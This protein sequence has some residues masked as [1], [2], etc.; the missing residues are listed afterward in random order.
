MIPFKLILSGKEPEA[1]ANLALSIV[2]PVPNSDGIYQITDSAGGTF[3]AYVD[4]TTD[5]GYWILAFRWT[6]PP[7]PVNSRTFN[8]LVVK[9]QPISGYSVLPATFPAIPAG[10]VTA[11]PATEYLLRSSNATWT[12]LFGTWQRMNTFNATTDAIVHNVGVPAVTSI[13]NRTMHGHRTGWGSPTTMNLVLGF[14]TVAGP[15]GHCGGAGIVGT[16]KCCPVG[17]QGDGGSHYDGTNSVKQV[18]LRA[19]NKP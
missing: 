10:R 17:S 3:P 15:N 12:S 11:N 7:A 6:L 1:P 8:N 2:N 18:Y 13:G 14:W 16:N 5:G 9:G 4:M 19:V